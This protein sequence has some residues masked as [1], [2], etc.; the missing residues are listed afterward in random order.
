MKYLGLIL[1]LAVLCMLFFSCYDYRT[2]TNDP[3][4]AGWFKNGVG[5]WEWNR[6]RDR[7]EWIRGEMKIQT[8]EIGDTTYSFTPGSVKAMKWIASRRARLR[9]T[10]IELGKNPDFYIDRNIQEGERRGRP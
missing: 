8:F 1:L 5:E 7:K 2:V 9:A 3:T 6:D 4:K 10:A